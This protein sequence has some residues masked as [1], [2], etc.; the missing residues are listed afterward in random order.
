MTKRITGALPKATP[1]QRLASMSLSQLML[2]A[3]NLAKDP[4]K[5]ILCTAVLDELEKR[6]SAGQFE[7]FCQEIFS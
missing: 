7:A 2:A 5:D 6:I 3:R 1:A 4:S